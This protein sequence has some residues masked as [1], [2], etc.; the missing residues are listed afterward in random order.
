MASNEKPQVDVPAD[1]S[2]SYQLE[3]EDI[4]VGD[5]DEA[6]D[7][8]PLGHRVAVAALQLD[9]P[10]LDRAAAAAALLQ[11][12]RELLQAG[13]VERDVGEGRDRLAAPPARLAADLDAPAGGDPCL[14]L[15]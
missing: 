7:A 2:P 12:P 10:A 6:V 13:V 3:L 14:E 4:E 5:G 11:A 8:R 15:R 1:Q 9:D